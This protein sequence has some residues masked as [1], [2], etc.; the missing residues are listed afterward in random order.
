MPEPDPVVAVGPHL[1][2]PA[3]A[4]LLR[5]ALAATGLRLEGWRLDSVHHRVGRSLSALYAARVATPDGGPQDLAV[6][7]HV[8]RGPVPPGP[9]E[10]VVADVRVNVWRF[11]DDPFLPGLPSATSPA[12]VRDLIDQLG[13]APGAVE[14]EVRSYRPSRRAVIEVAVRVPRSEGRV[15]YLKVLAG[16]RATRLAAVHRELHAAG[17]PVP[18]LVGVAPEQ[19]VLAIRALAGR[20]LRSALAGGAAVPA[21]KTL[22]AVSER[23][24]AAPLSA[25]AD[26][27]GFA[28][29]SR[30]VTALAGLVPDRA[31]DLERIAEVAR[32]IG[33]PHVAVHGDLHDAQLL[34]EGDRVVGVLDVDGA[35]EG[36]LAHDAGSLVAHLEAVGEVWPHVDARA[37][38]Y[39][40]EVADAYARLLD[41]RDLARGAAAAWLGLAT[42]PYRVQ[43]AGWERFTRARIDRAAAWARRAAEW[44]QRP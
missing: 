2:G 23:L 39:A 29:P 22:V 21:P 31:G 12:R 1:T 6:V 30:H 7:A 34:I 10:V 42:G 36:W 33:G 35:G 28:D 18:G 13:V 44:S 25:G 17:V 38:A 8:D 11:P 19:G 27:A 37:R 4:E 43:D 14:L 41:P 9:L 26:P 3:A 15:L 16:D 5:A 20:T 24:A 32:G 40:A